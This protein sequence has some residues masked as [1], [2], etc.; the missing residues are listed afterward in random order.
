MNRPSIALTLLVASLG[1]STSGCEGC[2]FHGTRL[3]EG[4]IEAPVVPRARVCAE[5]EG[6]DCRDVA[7]TKDD[8]GLGYSVIQ[9]EE[10]VAGITCH[11]P[12]PWLIVE[13]TGCRP[14]VVELRYDLGP[15]VLRCDPVEPLPTPA[16]AR[17]GPS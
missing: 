1:S 3:H 14:A 10:G 4:R 11:L 6:V 5:R 16:G 15:V 2:G 12:R 9:T 8:R 13:A 17:P 7:L